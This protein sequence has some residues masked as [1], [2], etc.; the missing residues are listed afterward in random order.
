MSNCGPG[1]GG[2]FTSTGIILVLYILLVII[3]CSSWIWPLRTLKPSR[4][5]GGF[6]LFGRTAAPG[7]NL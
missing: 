5:R 7:D 2:V 3:L 6:H 1:V 4:Y